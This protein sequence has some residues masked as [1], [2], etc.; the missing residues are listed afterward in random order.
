MEHPSDR[1]SSAWSLATAV[2]NAERLLSVRRER[3]I[4]F[5]TLAQPD[6]SDPAD[7]GTRSE[8]QLQQGR[9]AADMSP[10]DRN[11]GLSLPA[12]AWLIV[13]AAALLWA[14]AALVFVLLF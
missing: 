6:Q 11:H 8:N 1:R 13:G 7:N 10:A 9:K 5:A 12:R 2:A 14:I 3:D 4:A